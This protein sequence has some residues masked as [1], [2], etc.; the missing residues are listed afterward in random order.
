MGSYTADC[1]GARPI[2]YT[3]DS[4]AS[5]ER[6]FSGDAGG[7][8]TLGIVPYNGGSLDGF[9]DPRLLRELELTAPRDGAESLLRAYSK[10]GEIWEGRDDSQVLLMLLSSF[11]FPSLSLSLSPC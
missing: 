10:M 7:G 6:I 2:I 4:F 3:A 11:F 9:I 1:A 8:E 5:E